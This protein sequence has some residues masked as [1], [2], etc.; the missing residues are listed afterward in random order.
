MR[1]EIICTT[2]LGVTSATSGF[3]YLTDSKCTEAIP[4]VC[5]DM[6]RQTAGSILEYFGLWKDGEAQPNNYPFLVQGILQADPDVKYGKRVV[7]NNMSFCVEQTELNY[8]G[9]EGRLYKPMESK[10]KFLLA[11]VYCKPMAKEQ[12]TV[13]PTKLWLG[14]QAMTEKIASKASEDKPINVSILGARLE[15]TS[16]RDTTYFTIVSNTYPQ[17]SLG[18]PSSYFS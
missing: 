12:G 11:Q 7:I 18:L 3:L 8:V 5:R 17:F 13:F 16:Y 4:F 2:Q 14:N 1:A 9:L 15:V 10:Q 6:Y